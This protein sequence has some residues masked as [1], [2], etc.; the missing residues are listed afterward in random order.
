MSI[1]FNEH[2]NKQT[3]LKTEIVSLFKSLKSERI[4][5]FGFWEELVGEKLAKI[6]VP[7]SNKKGV[8]FVKV[9][10]PVWRFELTR[11]KNELLIKLK[12][13]CKRNSIKDIVF[14]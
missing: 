7:V 6:A 4:S 12:E 3:N 8:L 14:I 13:T 10:D 11:E 2:K 9:E 5:K 1:S